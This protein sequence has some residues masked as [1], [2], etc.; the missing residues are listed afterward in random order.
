MRATV[1]HW[2]PYPAEKPST[3]KGVEWFLVTRK[4]QCG[5]PFVGELRWFSE[6]GDDPAGFLDDDGD[7]YND[8]IAWAPLPEP[9]KGGA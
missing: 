6:F 9:Y 5:A 7:E 3:D 1:A 2:R 8:V 4:L